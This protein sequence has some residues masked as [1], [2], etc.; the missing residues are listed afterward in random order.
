MPILKDNRYEEIHRH[1]KKE[2]LR[3]RLVQEIEPTHKRK[4]RNESSLHCLQI[5][6]LISSSSES[7]TRKTK[8]SI[9]VSAGICTIYIKC[10]KHYP[11]CVFAPKYKYTPATIR[12]QESVFTCHRVASGDRLGASSFEKRTL[13]HRGVPLSYF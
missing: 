11:I 3:Q 10:F 13:A 7:G 9:H 5:L 4:M 2:T 1:T 12:C 8:K 6:A